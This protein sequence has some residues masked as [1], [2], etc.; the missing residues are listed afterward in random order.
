M[1]DEDLSD[2]FP[3]L[4]LFGEG[5]VD[6]LVGHMALAD[7]KLTKRPAALALRSYTLL[8]LLFDRVAQPAPKP[9]LRLEP[10]GLFG[11]CAVERSG[12]NEAAVEKDLTEP[13]LGPPLLGERARDVLVVEEPAH[14]EQLAQSATH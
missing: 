10:A 8:T 7:E 14:D 5:A 12:R 9:A 2:Q 4:R 3:A 11:E 13:A 6:L 1:R